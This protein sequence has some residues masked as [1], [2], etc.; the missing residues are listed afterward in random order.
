MPPSIA[1]AFT[2]LLAQA[3]TATQPPDLTLPPETAHV[4]TIV[5]GRG[6]QIYTC[7]ALPTGP[8]WTLKAPEAKLFNLATGQEVG[9]HDAGPTW[10]F[11]DGSAIHGTVLQK[12][13]ADTPADVPWLLLRADPAPSASPTPGTLTPVNLVRRYNT[14]GGNPPPTGCSTANPGG[15]LRVPYTATYAFYTNQA[16]APNQP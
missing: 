7:S 6:D 10:T 5:E 15:T 11:T 9:H 8:A 4:V 1:L 2:A 12:K 14:H 13:A 16:P 3:A